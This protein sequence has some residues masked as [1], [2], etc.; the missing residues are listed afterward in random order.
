MHHVLVGRL[1]EHRLVRHGLL[2]HAGTGRDDVLALPR[3]D[4]RRR[5]PRPSLQRRSPRCLELVAPLA[6]LALVHREAVSP[7]LS[8]VSLGSMRG[9]SV[10]LVNVLGG[11][12]HGLLRLGGKMRAQ[13]R[14]VERLV[15]GRPG[16]L[17]LWSGSEGTEAR[18]G[19]GGRCIA[20]LSR[21]Q[22]LR[23]CQRSE[24]AVCVSGVRLAGTGDL[25]QAVPGPGPAAA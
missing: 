9:T 25:S 21:Q 2:I 5:R 7:V 11:V 17:L 22:T 16:L 23:R 24:A 15:R 6:R 8:R 19:S 14:Q 12:V 18:A 20:I 10:G 1:L 3:S 4:R 13:L